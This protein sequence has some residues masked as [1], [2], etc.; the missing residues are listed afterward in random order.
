V[1]YKC[2]GSVF[3]RQL[4]LHERINGALSNMWNGYK[5]AANLVSLMFY[6]HCMSQLWWTTIQRYTKYQFHMK[7]RGIMVLVAVVTEAQT[8]IAA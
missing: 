8:I 5:K 3:Q 2:S 6:H 1:E 4:V 7:P